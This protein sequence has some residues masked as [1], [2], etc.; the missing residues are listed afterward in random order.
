MQLH[1]LA[2]VYQKNTQQIAEPIPMNLQKAEIQCD[3]VYLWI[4]EHS[5]GIFGKPL[6]S[7]KADKTRI[8]GNRLTLW[9]K[10]IYDGIWV[11]ITQRHATNYDFII[12]YI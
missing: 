4:L 3:W 11:S 1:H 6:L 12:W 5:L 2:T 9:P 7:F 10:T 8:T